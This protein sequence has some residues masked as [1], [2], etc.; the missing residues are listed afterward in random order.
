[1]IILKTKDEIEIMREG[2]QILADI[3]E[4][5]KKE[6]RPGVTT[7]EL[8]SLADKLISEKGEPSFKHVRGY[9]WATCMC[10]NDVVVHGIPNNY[11]LKEGD[12]LGID[13]GMIYKGFNSDMSWTMEIQNS[14]FRIQNNKNNEIDKFLNTGKIA[15]ERAIK[16]AKVGN[17][18]GHISKA[19]QDTIESAG[20]AP[21]KTLVGHGIGKNLH[22]EP[23]IPGFLKGNINDTP[24]LNE[25]MTIAIEVIYNQGSPEVIYGNDDGWTIK[26][27]NNKLSG[28]F[29]Q[30][31]AIL[32]SGPEVL[33]VATN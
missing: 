14:E 4:K 9:Q 12:I 20:Y 11:K 28:L 25:G 1:M 26:T 2:G 13:I 22:E 17:H 27:I 5:I 33:T 24:K 21:V 31:I 29:E 7:L 6:V 30:T 18:I 15:L 19:I 3:M 8:D 32:S 10:V 16:Q 23:Q